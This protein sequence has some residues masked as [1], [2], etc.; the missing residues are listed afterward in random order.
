M[1]Y[2]HWMIAALV[3][4]AVLACGL[5]T[6]RLAEGM[7][8][9]SSSS[10]K[11]LHEGA[12]FVGRRGGRVTVVRDAR[13]RIALKVTLPPHHGSGAPLYFTLLKNGEWEGQ[14]PSSRA[15][16]NRA[17]RQLHVY[18]RGTAHTFDLDGYEDED[19]GVVDDVGDSN[20]QY[21]GST[22]QRY[23]H[24]WARRHHRR[25]ARP[26]GIRRRDIPRGHEDLYVLKTSVVPP[27][28]PACA[29]YHC[30]DRHANVTHV[31]PAT[32]D[33]NNPN[34]LLPIDD[35]FSPFALQRPTPTT[36]ANTNT[37]DPTATAS[38]SNAPLPQP[39]SCEATPFSL[40][41]NPADPFFQDDPA[42][43]TR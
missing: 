42:Q 12:S 11:W 27:L 25:P 32:T 43:R 41:D 1:L 29:D 36:N 38:N 7:S 3:C 18:H 24:M 40:L 16:H 9:S 6:H 19:D 34:P 10:S 33:D 13:G 23:S 2:K 8:T 21:F 26:D 37:N 31:P 22:G 14:D 35:S 39:E 4:G 20:T 5:A 30:R 17:Y 15:Y 28:C